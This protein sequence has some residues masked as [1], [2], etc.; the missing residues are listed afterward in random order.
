MPDF[1]FTTFIDCSASTSANAELDL[2]GATLINTAQ[3]STIFATA[4]E[5]NASTVVILG[6]ALSKK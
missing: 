2:T 6:E 3:G 5:A 4:V 1:G